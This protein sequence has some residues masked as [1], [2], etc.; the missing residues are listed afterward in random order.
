MD[1]RFFRSFPAGLFAIT[2]FFV[3]VAGLAAGNFAFSPPGGW[4]AHER[5]GTSNK[6]TDPTGL[7][8]VSLFTTTYAGNLSTFVN[9]EL[10][11]E[12]AAYPSQR[13]FTN[14][15]YLI[16][17]RHTGRYLIWTSGSNGKSLIHEQM[18]ALWGDDGYII[19]YVRPANRPPDNTA[20]ASLLSICGV[21][22]GV[23]TPGGVPVSPANPPRPPENAP[24]PAPTEAPTPT[25]YVYPSLYPRYVPVVPR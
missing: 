4:Q 8:S 12:R 2:L 25:P 10:H 24:S 9:R 17:S 18:L 20:R 14:K 22:A 5:V 21:G 6:W 1:G 23:I 7:E 13:V 3:G 15:N 11:R 16:C 19:T